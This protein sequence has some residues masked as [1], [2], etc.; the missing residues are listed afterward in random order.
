MPLTA[1]PASRSEDAEAVPSVRVIDRYAL[2]G[3]IASGGMA[4]VHV[5]RL[6]GPAGF[7]R[8]VAIKRLHSQFARDPE[9]VSMFLDEARL[10]ARIRHPNVIPTLDVVAAH[11]ELFLVMEY[12]QGESL[13]VLLREAREQELAIPRGVAVS[14]L[15]GCLYG[16]HAAHGAC[17]EHGNGLGIVHRDVSPQNVIVGVDG[18]AR[19]FDFGVAKAI[20]RMQ[21]TREGQVKGKLAYMAPEQLH[22]RSVTPQADVYA[23]AVVAWETLTGTRLF[24]GDNEAIVLARV[25]AGQI[26]PPSS[27][28]ADLAPFDAVVMKGLASRPEERWT[29]AREMALALE[30]CA[31]PASPAMVSE[32]LE[33]VAGGRLR[34]R[35]DQVSRI[36][37][38]CRGDQPITDLRNRVLDELGSRA[39]PPLDVRPHEGVAIEVPGAVRSRGFDTATEQMAPRTQQVARAPRRAIW[40]LVPI[41]ATASALGTLAVV[42]RRDAT[43]NEAAPTIPATSAPG[44]ASLEPPVSPPPGGPAETAEPSASAGAPSAETTHAPERR[45]S[46]ARPPAPARSN[47]PYR[48]LGGRR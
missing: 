47:D 28:S 38:S 48:G 31:P 16:L 37:S 15:S 25:M 13:A 18:M 36:E 4:T 45:P 26:D 19:V 44:T 11:G 39:A 33:G 12:V 7:S 1:D 23:A 2:Y 8:T 35:A 41:I 10:A 9:F 40:W 43:T 20:G 46:G 17:D 30:R 6:L 24:F 5:G 21:T 32:W 22:A 29:T 34:E 42:G 3:A 27:I 14:I